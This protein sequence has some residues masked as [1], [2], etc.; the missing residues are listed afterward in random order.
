MKVNV[1][2]VFPSSFFYLR[3]VVDLRAVRLKMIYAD[4]GDH[5]KRPMLS[6]ANQ[7]AGCLHGS[8]ISGEL[9]VD[10]G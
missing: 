7:R 1:F 6:K 5:S 10:V 9:I 2:S 8:T 3:D 4:E